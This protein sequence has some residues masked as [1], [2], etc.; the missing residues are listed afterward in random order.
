[1]YIIAF[2]CFCL[3]SS[4]NFPVP[5]SES[6]EKYRR[7]VRRQQ[8]FSALQG[9]NSKPRAVH[10]LIVKWLTVKSCLLHSAGAGTV[11]V[12]AKPGVNHQARFTDLRGQS[13]LL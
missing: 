4:C 2:S 13:N 9:G 1:M 10:I 8:L 7:D 6:K 11:T 5:D 12:L 3:R